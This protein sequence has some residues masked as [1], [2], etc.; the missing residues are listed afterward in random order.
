M[1]ASDAPAAGFLNRNYDN[2]QKFLLT[3]RPEWSPPGEIVSA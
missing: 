2:A 1:L 3:T